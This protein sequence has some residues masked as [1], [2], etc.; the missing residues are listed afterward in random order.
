MQNW[1]KTKEKLIELDNSWEQLY[2]KL[3]NN[4]KQEDLIEPVLLGYYT[5]SLNLATAV[6]ESSILNASFYIANHTA[7][8]IEQLTICI[9]IDASL[10]YQFSGK[11]I[12]ENDHGK[13]AGQQTAWQLVENNHDQYWFTYLPEEG[14]LADRT[15]QFANFAITW[16]AEEAYSLSI[17]GFIYTNEYPDGQA[18]LNPI[19]IAVT[20]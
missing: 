12:N 4:H 3:R 1:E 15:I 8:P 10:P 9:K 7:K 14:L 16:K 11:Y 19:F 6:N 17:E 18:V 2:Q 13:K 20:D 5:H